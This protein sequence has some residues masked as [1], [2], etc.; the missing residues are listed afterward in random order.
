MAKAIHQIDTNNGELTVGH[1]KFLRIGQ[2]PQAHPGSVKQTVTDGDTVSVEADGNF[3]VRFL[4]VDAPETKSRCPAATPT[5]RCSPPL[6]TPP[7]SRC[8]PTPSPP[9]CPPST[10]T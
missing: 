9:P 10:P 6:P 1:A 5:A 3:G 2:G 4:G 8:S 7:G